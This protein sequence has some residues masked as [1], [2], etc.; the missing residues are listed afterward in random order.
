[1]SLDVDTITKVLSLALSVGAMVFAF[2]AN[3]RKD[4]DA[5]IGALEAR[6]TQADQKVLMLEAKLEAVPGK[7][8]LHDLKLQI[9]RQTGTLEVMAAN[10]EGNARLMSRVEAIVS[11]HEE[12]LL[13]QK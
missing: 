3:R 2:F 1:M 10:M 8:E 12:H 5:K 11:R 9:T 13:G 6:Q 4:V 7:D